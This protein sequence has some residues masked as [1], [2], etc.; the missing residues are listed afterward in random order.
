MNI[1]IPLDQASALLPALHQVVQTVKK[2]EKQQ[3]SESEPLQVFHPQTV[4]VGGYLPKEEKLVFDASNYMTYQIVKKY[5]E[6]IS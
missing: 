3:S 4:E 1:N 6:T 5:C 2:N